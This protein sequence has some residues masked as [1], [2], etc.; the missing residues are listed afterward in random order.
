MLRRG[1]RV[2]RGASLR[3]ALPCGLACTRRIMSAV[4]PSPP[5]IQR[6]L[7]L[8]AHAGCSGTRAGSGLP[9]RRGRAHQRGRAHGLLAH[10]ALVHVARRL[11]EVRERRERGHHAQHGRRVRLRVRERRRGRALCRQ[12]VGAPARRAAQPHAPAADAEGAAR[13]PPMAYRPRRVP[14]RSQEC[15]TDTGLDVSY[16]GGSPALWL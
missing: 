15:P 14:R 2:L 1:S 9:G 6:Q 10:L 11:V 13:V 7:A 5:L 12:A 16:P 3:A 4:L 8:D